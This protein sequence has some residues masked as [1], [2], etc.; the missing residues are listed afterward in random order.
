MSVTQVFV[1][2]LEPPLQTVIAA[3]P[4]GVAAG[5]VGVESLGEIVVDFAHPVKFPEQFYDSL[6]ETEPLDSGGACVSFRVQLA[7]QTDG[8]TVVG[9]TPVELD[10]LG[11]AAA[12]LRCL[13]VQRERS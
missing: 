2:T 1:G 5:F 11:D 8:D 9:K 10:A 6:R 4:V 12:C 7:A 3:R 13:V